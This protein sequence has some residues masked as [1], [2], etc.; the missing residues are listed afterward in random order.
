MLA[1][2]EVFTI[3]LVSCINN[4]S[5]LRRSE[6][7]TIFWA[8][9]MVQILQALFTGSNISTVV[10][11]HS[12]PFTSPATFVKSRATL[13]RFM[14]FLRDYPVDGAANEKPIL[15]CIVK[16]VP[17]SDTYNIYSRLTI[18]EQVRK[19]TKVIGS[20]QLLLFLRRWMAPIKLRRVE[21]T[22]NTS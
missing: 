3:E 2:W 18:L 17:L 14:L 16:G 21:W 22:P 13:T 6:N 1:R 7:N 15:L 19:K 5:G 20:P 10:T 9:T 8:K 12:K 4:L 11:N